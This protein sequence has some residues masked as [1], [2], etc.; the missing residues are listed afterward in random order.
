MA[1]SFGLC[2]VG[3][4]SPFVVTP[5]YLLLLPENC[6]MTTGQSQYAGMLTT[7][8]GQPHFHLQF[9]ELLPL[10]ESVESLK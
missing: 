10:A 2:I 3:V 4:I 5:F 9:K 7:V 1:C 6:Q 8:V